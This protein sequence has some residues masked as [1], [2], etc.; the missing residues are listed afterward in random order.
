MFKIKFICN[1]IMKIIRKTN[2]INTNK[3]FANVLILK[4]L[5]HFFGETFCF[6]EEFEVLVKDLVFFVFEVCT[7]ELEGR[8]DFF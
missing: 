8:V 2:T 7:E 4:Y 1:E 5:N 6:G 3:I